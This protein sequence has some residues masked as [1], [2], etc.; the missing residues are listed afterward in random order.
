MSEQDLFLNDVW[1]EE[2][3]SHLKGKGL[4]SEIDAQSKL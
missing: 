4:G 1:Q 2:Y 3:G